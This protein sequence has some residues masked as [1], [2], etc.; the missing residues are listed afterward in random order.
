MNIDKKTVCIVALGSRMGDVWV[1]ESP[2]LYQVTID[3][4]FVSPSGEYIRMGMNPGDEITGWQL[5]E[6]LI[7][8]EVLAEWEGDQ[9]P[10]IT[11]GSDGVEMSEAA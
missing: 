9:P 5:V 4:A 3:P 6:R 8:I 2:I 11:L 1:Q 7:L 10:V